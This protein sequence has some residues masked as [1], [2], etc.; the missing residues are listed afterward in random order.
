MACFQEHRQC[1]V[2]DFRKLSSLRRPKSFCETGLSECGFLWAEAGPPGRV[3]ALTEK[4]PCF[5]QDS[6]ESAI[7]GE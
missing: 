5:Q 3:A 2:Q 6:L 1:E 7:L 4:P